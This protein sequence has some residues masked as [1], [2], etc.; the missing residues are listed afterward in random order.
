MRARC[1]SVLTVRL[2]LF[3]LGV[4]LDAQMPPNT[5][6]SSLEFAFSQATFQQ[7]ISLF[8]NNASANQ[9]L[10]LSIGLHFATSFC[11]FLGLSALTAWAANHDSIEMFGVPGAIGDSMCYTAQIG[12]GTEMV[13]LSMLTYAVMGSSPNGL[14]LPNIYFV[15]Y[16]VC[17]AMKDAVLGITFL[18]GVIVRIALWTCCKGVDNTPPFYSSDE[19]RPIDL[20]ANDEPIGL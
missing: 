11:L 13:G 19:E 10:L 7:R 8:I 1:A 20:K 14:N 6:T 3:S 17:L 4:G 15:C 12:W 2:S 18:Y 9:L 5:G 16:G